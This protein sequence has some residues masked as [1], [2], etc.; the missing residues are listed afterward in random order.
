MNT[1]QYRWAVE[2]DG[3]REFC[4][5]RSEARKAAAQIRRHPS[6]VNTRR[7]GPYANCDGIPRVVDTWDAPEHF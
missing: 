2:I 4:K 5:T 6:N 3:E 1:N 7:F